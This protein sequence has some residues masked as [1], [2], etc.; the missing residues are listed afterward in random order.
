S[1][2]KFLYQKA[3]NKGYLEGIEK[4]GKVEKVYE[5]CD[6]GDLNLSLF[7]EAYKILKENYLDPSRLVPKE[8]IYGAIRGMVESLGDPYT[9]FLTPEEAKIFKEDVKGEFEG[10]G[11]EI[12]IKDGKLTIISPLEGTPAQRAGLKA[13][14]VIVK[15]NDKSTEGM[16]LDEAV[17]LIRGP[18]G[19]TVRLT[20]ERRGWSQAKEFEI[21]RARIQIPTIKWEKK[22]DI[23]YLKIYQFLENTDSIFSDEA[24]KI[25]RIP[26]Q[27]MILDLRNNPGGYFEIAVKIGGWFIK[28]GSTIAVEETRD[29]G[30]IEYKSQGPAKFEDY[31][32]VVLINKGTAS[33]AEILAAA[34]KENNSSVILIGEETFGKNTVQKLEPLSDNSMIKITIANWLTPSGKKISETGLSPDIKVE[35]KEEDLENGKDV[36]LEK[37]IEI[38]KK[39]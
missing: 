5:K 12:G 19:T 11:V 25:L 36:Q 34:L 4:V 31:K 7:F 37:A 32:I 3:Y 6:F 20:V 28:K 24:K 38:L 39:I 14:D 21:E 29:K 1:G 33:A 8:L 9:N 22:E 30:K 10:I 27:K 26:T 15:I 16:N 35:A 2:G 17:R 23:L 18:K 13:G